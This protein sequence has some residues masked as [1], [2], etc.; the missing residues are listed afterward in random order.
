MINCIFHSKHENKMKAVAGAFLIT[1]IA[2]AI[3]TAC[4]YGTSWTAG[5]IGIIS[6]SGILI[7]LALTYLVVIQI[8]NLKTHGYGI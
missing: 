7:V 8:K 6:V 5:S 4:L 1:A 2:L 3:L